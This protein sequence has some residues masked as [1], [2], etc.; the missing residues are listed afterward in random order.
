MVLGGNRL[1]LLLGCGT[2]AVEIAPLGLGLWRWRVA[3]LKLRVHACQEVVVVL[4]ADGESVG[5]RSANLDDAAVVE[6]ADEVL[7]LLRA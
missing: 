2:L 3:L 5:S 1:E 7:V 6:L 4:Q